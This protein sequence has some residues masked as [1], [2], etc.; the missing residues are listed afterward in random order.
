[1]VNRSGERGHPMSVPD[2]REHEFSLS[3]L[4][5]ILGIGFHKFC[6]LD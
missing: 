4:S 5:T 2:F 1:M 3:P 6:L